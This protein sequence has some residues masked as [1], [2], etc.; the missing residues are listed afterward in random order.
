MQSC[1][2]VI[3]KDGERLMPTKRFGRVRRLLKDGKAIIVKHRP[4]TIQLVYEI[5]TYTQ[6][7]EFCQDTGYLYIGNSL[8]SGT[9]EYVNEEL[10]LL[11]D[12][13]QRH[14]DCRKYR[15]SRRNRLRYR[16][17]RF[18]NR[19]RPE[20]WLAPS[21]QHK[22][23]AHINEVLKYAAVAPITDVYIEVGEFDPA[24]LKAII[25]GEAAPRGADYQR[26]DL[27]EKESVR[28]AVFQRDG[29]RC[30]FCGRGTE[31]GAIL[32]VH[33]ALFWKGRH[34]SQLDELATV[35]EKCHT[36]ANHK[37]GGLLWG[38]IPKQFANLENATFMNTVRWYIYNSLKEQLPDVNVHMTYGAKTSLKRKH[39]DLDKT[40]GN[41]A[42]C[43]GMF[44][45][46][47][48]VEQRVF[49]KV[50]RNN[51]ILSKF[52][53]SKYIDIRDGKTKSGSELG[54]QRVN[55]RE[56]KNSEKNL[57]RF[58]GTKISKGRRSVRTRHYEIRPGD[59]LLWKNNPQTAVGVH[60]KGSRVM[61]Q[62][63]K[64]VALTQTKKIR[65]IGGW[66]FLHA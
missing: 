46:E 40:H 57:R 24:L 65:Q 30:C 7:M 66:Q 3:S 18:N 29:F 64:S 13:K 52:Y 38:Y 58:R 16:E 12:E 51:R 50:R 49:Q 9:H 10:I 47:D 34:G 61:L 60:N 59:I 35:C 62:N 42:Y 22:A 17:P 56:P 48:R 2:F 53:D 25:K 33:H 4:F 5:S 27:Y 55:R 14:D 15:R 6:P 26:G 44:R 11:K 54:S 23:D 28:K 43:M 32:H 63:K 45:P 31:D 20:G 37:E 19:K 1:V 36:S 39:L 41:D 21:L 8:K